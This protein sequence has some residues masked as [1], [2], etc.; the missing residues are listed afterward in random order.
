[1][2]QYFYIVVCGHVLDNKYCQFYQYHDFNACPF[3]AG[4]ML[5]VWLSVFTRHLPSTANTSLLDI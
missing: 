1:M 3:E 2:S 5:T 4:P